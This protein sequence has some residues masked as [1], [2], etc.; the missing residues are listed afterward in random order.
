MRDVEIEL[1]KWLLRHEHAS[2]PSIFG[3]GG[4][5]HERSLTRFAFLRFAEALN[6]STRLDR[7]NE[8]DLKLRLALILSPK[9]A[10]AWN[11]TDPRSR[12]EVVSN[13]LTENFELD[14]T[15]AESISRI[16][17]GTLKA[18]ETSRSSLSDK[19]QRILSDQEGACA[20]CHVKINEDRIA[21][22][23][24]KSAEEQDVYKPY[25]ADPGVRTW[26]TPE[27]DHIE[28]ISGTGSN[29]KENLQVL[30]KLCNSGKENGSGISIQTEFKHCGLSVREANPHY[31]RRLLYNR[32]EMD[33]FRCTACGSSERELTVRPLRNNGALVL[34]NLT[35]ICYDCSKDST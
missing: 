30:C 3:V 28:P 21:I 34:L 26:F 19:A 5:D 24:G 4:T 1:C 7:I 17:V 29:R 25:F 18:W 23:E 15:E 13:Y 14:A 22:E 33:H 12:V 2:V 20:A 11:P 10:I 8:L 9:D 31:R 6:L 35:S 32:I 27:V 16:V